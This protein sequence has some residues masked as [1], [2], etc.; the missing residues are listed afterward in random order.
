[1]KSIVGIAAIRVGVIV[2]ICEGGLIFFFRES[3]V[4]R[5]S[6]R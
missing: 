2:A 5:A 6:V 3:F 1:M 4:V